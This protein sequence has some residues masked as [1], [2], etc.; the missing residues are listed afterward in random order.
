MQAVVSYIIITF[1]PQFQKMTL[2]SVTL[3]TFSTL[4]IILCLLL[5]MQISEMFHTPSTN[6]RQ[7]RTATETVC[8]G[9]M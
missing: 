2:H 7:S 6:C 4:V 1:F 9:T 8:G 3:S 5:E